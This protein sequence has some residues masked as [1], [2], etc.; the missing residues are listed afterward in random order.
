MFVSIS[1]SLS[2][3]VLSQ[4]GKMMFIKSVLQALPIFAMSVFLL[5]KSLC[6]DMQAIMAKYWWHNSKQKR[7]IHWCSWNTLCKPKEDGGLGFI[8]MMK[9]NV[10]LL[11]KQG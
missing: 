7:G 3:N 6:L 4:G 9:F 5:L 11:V 8:D 10:A 2:L 1:S